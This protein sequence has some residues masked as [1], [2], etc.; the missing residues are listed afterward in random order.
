MVVEVERTV[1]VDAPREEVWEV[2]S[3]PERRAR[4]VSVVEDF[5]VEGEEYVWAVRVPLVRKTVSVRTR[6]VERDPP[7]FVRFAGDSK[8]FDVEGEHELT[9]VEAG[10]EIRS[11][12]VVDGKFPGV[13]RFFEKNVDDEIDNLVDAFQEA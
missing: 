3:D 12:F 11:R 4:V 1:T 13:E 2:L 8:V 7:R 9:E 5:R 10:T 6:D